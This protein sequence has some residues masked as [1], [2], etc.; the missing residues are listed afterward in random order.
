MLMKLYTEEKFMN[1]IDVESVDKY[2]NYRAI[3]KLYL[4]IYFKWKVV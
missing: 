3:K 2:K 4:I 1:Y